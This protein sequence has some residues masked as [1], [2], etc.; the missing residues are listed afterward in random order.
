MAD[1]AAEPREGFGGVPD[2]H[3]RPR[4]R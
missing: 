2:T 4:A 1:A 3:P